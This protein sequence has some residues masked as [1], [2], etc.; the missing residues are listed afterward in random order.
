MRF[1]FILLLLSACKT[2]LVYTDNFCLWFQPVTMTEEEVKLVSDQTLLDI[3][4]VN[5]QYEE[6][7]K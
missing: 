2:K 1:L 7:C 5:Q 6:Q 3:Y 4:F